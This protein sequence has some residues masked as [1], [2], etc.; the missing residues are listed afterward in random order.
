MLTLVELGLDVVSRP[1]S[2]P[3]PHLALVRTVEGSVR[4]VA[5]LGVGVAALDDKA[6]DDAVESLTHSSLVRS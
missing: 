3:G 1:A 2:T 4:S 6:L 5:D